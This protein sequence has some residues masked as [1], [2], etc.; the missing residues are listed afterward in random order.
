MGGPTSISNKPAPEAS[1]PPRATR[2]VA[3]SVA[4][5]PRPPAA[6]PFW[7][8]SDGTKT[9]GKGTLSQ[10]E[11]AK[12]KKDALRHEKMLPGAS[13]S[14]AKAGPRPE[15]T[16]ALSQ[17][18]NALRQVA[19]G[20]VGAEM[21]ERALRLCI[22]GL[23]P[24]EKKQVILGLKSGVQE[25]EREQ[26][27]DVV[28][29]LETLRA[30]EA[31]GGSSEMFGH[32]EGLIKALGGQPKAISQPTFGAKPRMLAAMDAKHVLEQRAQ[33]ADLSEPATRPDDAG[34]S[35][36]NLTGPL[37]HNGISPDDLTQG[38][39]GDCGLISALSALADTQPQA[40]RDAIKLVRENSDGSAV[41]GVRFFVP[42]AEGPPHPLV[43]H[44]TTKAYFDRGFLGLG[45]GP[46][47]ARS[48]RSDDASKAE[49][50]PILIEKAYAKL[51]GSFQTLDKDGEAPNFVFTA[52]TGRA[53]TEHQV[54]GLSDGAL[55]HKLELM[56]RK[57]LPVCARTPDSGKRES[58]MGEGI[59][60]NHAY[61]IRDVGKNE[62]GEWVIRV[63]NPWGS[64]GDHG[65]QELTLAQ[66]RRY[67]EGV[68]TLETDE[69][70]EAPPSRLRRLTP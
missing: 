42:S 26:R 22:T 10:R 58:E 29:V 54:S 51:Q 70:G 23:S 34:K 39:A 24:N 3:E 48:T 41:Y 8:D 33:D 55:V 16:R 19:D 7:A 25:L 5:P 57:H 62:K 18:L 47:Y 67:F 49:M 12:L 35:L 2:K 53:S 44:V 38:K 27:A 30:D 45:A 64:R 43:V 66:F 4:P 6:V 20:R 46:T 65:E 52:L 56:K 17:T 69:Q 1:V 28:T 63:R 15:L 68:Y 61:S 14:D 36:R 59:V 13:R 32:Y 40:I 9:P 50:W 21:T 31:H 11:R 60:A 37:F